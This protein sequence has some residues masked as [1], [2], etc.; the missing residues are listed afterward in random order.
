[1]IIGMGVS[2]VN[3][4]KNWT[5]GLNGGIPV[6][7]VE[8]AYSFHASADVAYRID[9]LK[10]L[11]IGATAGY[12]H[13]FGKSFDVESLQFEA[14]DLQFIPLAGTARLRI[15]SLLFVGTD[16]GYAIGVGSDSD[17]GF[18]VRPQIGVNLGLVN[19]LASY[20]NISNDG[21]NIASINAG[22]EVKF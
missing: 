1:M 8:E 7:D 18:Y 16:L 3:A 12:A 22:V 5:F 6:G 4:Q 10:L 9:I 20:S 2:N 14:E 21:A 17:G 19:V 13:Y 15:L 11:D